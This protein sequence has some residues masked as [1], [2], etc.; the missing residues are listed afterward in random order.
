MSVDKFGHHHINYNNCLKKQSP[1]LISL[2]FKLTPEGDI[3]FEFRKLKNISGAEDELDAVTKHQ[4]DYVLFQVRKQKETI[5]T[6]YNLITGFH[7]D[8]KELVD[9][10]SFLNAKLDRMEYYLY[11]V[12]THYT[13]RVKG[14]GRLLSQLQDV[15]DWLNWINT[16]KSDRN[17]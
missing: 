16:Y 11:L 10:K 15:D 3:N 12:S 1:S 13:E 14:G 4:L 17:I 5:N 6:L 7:K 2:P 8:I 9:S